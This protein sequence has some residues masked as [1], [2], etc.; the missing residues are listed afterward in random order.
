M[1]DTDPT[2]ASTLRQAKGVVGWGLVFW[3][4]AQ[5]ATAVFAQNATALAAIQA[6]LAEWGA[7]RI[8]IAWSDPVGQTPTAR[9]IGLRAARGLAMGASA[10]ALVTLVAFATGSAVLAA[11]RP[12]L[13]LLAVGLV[14]ALL[15]AVRDELFLR[16]IVLRATAGL[17]PAWAALATCGAAATAARYGL[18]GAIGP[19]LVVEALRGIALAAIWM[20]DRGAWMAVA[21]NTAWTWALGSVV[22]GGIVDVRFATA[23]DSGTAA[24]IV[25]GAGAAAAA[26][27]AMPRRRRT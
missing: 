25:V 14:I 16:G 27:W 2:R 13:G 26:F 23:S 15:R 21:A 19:V 24:L 7:G 11:G 5:L 6:A 18:D 9:S 12:T 10:A 3:G 17:W 8:G 1:T 22:R 4:G 20:K